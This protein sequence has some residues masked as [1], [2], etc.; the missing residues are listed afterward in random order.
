VPIQTARQQ[1]AGAAQARCTGLWA[2]IG[3]DHGKGVGMGEPL[4]ALAALMAALR[5]P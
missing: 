2:T 5:W 1:G 4:T 3:D